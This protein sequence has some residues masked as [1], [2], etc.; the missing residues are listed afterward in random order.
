MRLTLRV[1]LALISLLLLTIPFAGI[2]VSEF[3]K[4]EQLKVRE[5]TLLFSAKAVSSALSGRPSLFDKELFHSGTIHSDLYLHSLTNHIRLNGKVDDWESQLKEAQT[6]GEEHVVFQETAYSPESLSFKHI[7]GVRGKFLYTL[8]LVTDDTVVYR[9]PQSLSLDRSDYL[10]IDIEDSNSITT[11][12]LLTASKPGWVNGFA[13]PGQ[14]NKNSQPVSEPRIQGVWSDTPEGYLIELRFPMT[15]VGTK[16]AFAIGD[17]DDPASRN[18]KYVISTTTVGDEH[19]LGS[20]VTA[21]TEIQDI[22]ESLDR[23]HSR[24]HIVDKDRRLRASH[25]TLSQPG[26][27]LTEDNSLLSKISRISF[28]LF[29]P[30]YR[31]FM[32]PF[33]TDVTPVTVRKLATLELV[34][35]GDALAGTPTVTNYRIEKDIEQG[36]EIMAAIAPLYNGDD[37]VGAVVVEQTTNSILALQNRIIEEF[38][39]LTIL[40]FFIA[41]F[42]II[43]F[44]FRLSSRI[45]RLGKQAA[46]AIDTSGQIFTTIP[47]SQAKDEIGDL[48]RTLSSMLGQVKIQTEF[49]EKMADNLEHEM[50]TPLAGISASLKNLAKELESPAPHIQ[51]Y[52]DWAV[53]DVERLEAL[54]RTIRDATN[55]QQTLAHDE[56]EEFDI[57]KALEMWLEHSWQ[58]AFPGVTFIYEGPSNPVCFYGDP[59][60]LHQLLD[61]LVENAVSFHKEGTAIQLGLKHDEGSQVVLSVTNEGPVIP[62]ELRPQI[63]NSMVSSR[64]QN[65]NQ[66][67]LGLG[68][69][70]AR[71]IT[72]Q[73]G[74][75]IL[76]ETCES[77]PGTR[78]IVTLMT[79]I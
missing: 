63:F 10:Q 53:E 20:L 21:S 6:F 69:Y 33:A 42:S 14:G 51:E 48:S 75:T 32:T 7:S 30:M 13:L 2:R 49:R 4:K 35:I 1:K 31:F 3:I 59:G 39:T 58:P 18:K 15:M 36:I 38:I 27:D 37:V 19:N 78:F 26:S 68:L 47:D 66:P 5:D 62:E 23:P 12:Y 52:L 57:T 44:A 16:L 34:G 65:D 56:K 41:G 54:L 24:I 8:F 9:S 55:L 11:K 64:K 60:R 43:L 73:Y 67:H 22:L 74:G 50:R 79:M 29:S 25:G 76:A 61:K 70:I 77:P 40:L 17:I 46:K 28:R 45:R 72:S 71:E